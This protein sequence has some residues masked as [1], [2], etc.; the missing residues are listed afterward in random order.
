MNWCTSFE[1]GDLIRH[2]NSITFKEEGSLNTRMNVNINFGADRDE[3]TG[4]GLVLLV[5][6]QFGVS[7]VVMGFSYGDT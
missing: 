6:E 2:L 1:F 4:D 7:A 3:G 5:G